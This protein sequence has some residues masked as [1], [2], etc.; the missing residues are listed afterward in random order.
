MARRT[1]RA[2]AKPARSPKAKSKK[3]A[4]AKVEVVEEGGGENGDTGIAIVTT[5]AL[6]AAILLVDA[7]RGR[8]DT[9][10]FF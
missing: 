8:Y 5:L 2:A 7:L 1:S 4:A 9:G 3:P 10:M 6:F